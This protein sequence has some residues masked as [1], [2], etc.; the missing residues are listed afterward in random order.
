[1]EEILDAIT[2]ASR[3]LD[4]ASKREVQRRLDS[5]EE[6]AT[7]LPSHVVNILTQGKLC[8]DELGSNIWGEL[9]L[10]DAV[11]RLLSSSSTNT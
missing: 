10:S 5:T 6:L 1:M 8:F 2:D 9:L 4:E 3:V 7:V 11:V